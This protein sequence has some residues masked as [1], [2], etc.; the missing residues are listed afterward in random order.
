M[1]GLQNENTALNLVALILF[2]KQLMICAL[3]LERQKVYCF[4]RYTIIMNLFAEGC[5]S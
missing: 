1:G 3:S 2:Q 4:S 5:V